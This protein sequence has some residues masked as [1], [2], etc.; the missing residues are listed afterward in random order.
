V[1]ISPFRLGAI[2]ENHGPGLGVLSNHRLSLLDVPGP[3]QNA[4][5]GGCCNAITIGQVQIEAVGPE[6]GVSHNQRNTGHFLPGSKSWSADASIN[7]AI[8]WFG[9]FEHRTMCPATYHG[10]LSRRIR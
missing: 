7:P 5:M 1:A 3:Q 6:M 9:M 10:W 8:A 4:V 2:S